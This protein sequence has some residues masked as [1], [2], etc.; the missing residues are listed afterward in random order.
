MRSR[1]HSRISTNNKVGFALPDFAIKPV[2]SVSDLMADAYV[3]LVDAQVANVSSQLRA[4]RLKAFAQ[5]F[6]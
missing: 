5:A 3:E 6:A 2:S 4:A 1:S